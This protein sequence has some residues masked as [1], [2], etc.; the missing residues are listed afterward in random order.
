MKNLPT[1]VIEAQ[2]LLWLKNPVGSDTY[3]RVVET[4]KKYPE[5]FPWETKYN[6]ID[7]SVHR[8]Y[9]DEKELLF[10]SFFPPTP[11]D[12]QPGEGMYA[13]MQRQNAEVISCNKPVDWDELSRNMQNKQ[14][15]DEDFSKAKQKLWIKHYKKFNLKYQE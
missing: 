4:V 2:C 15:R 3:N 8:A 13:Y 11:M 1:E 7:D 5:H 6:S 10:N 14:K 9:E 12:I